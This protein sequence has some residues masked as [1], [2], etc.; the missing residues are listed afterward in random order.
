M[1]IAIPNFHANNN[2]VVKAWDGI[3]YE[4]PQGEGTQEEPYLINSAEELFWV[5]VQTEMGTL[6]GSEHFLLTSDIIIGDNWEPIGSNINNA[7]SGNFD[8]NNYT[9]KSL[10]YNDSQTINS[11]LGLFGVIN[12]A[13][14]S[15]L[16][17]SNVSY[18]LDLQNY[19]N[20]LFAGA[21]AGSIINSTISNV[22]TKGNITINNATENIYL[23]GLAGNVEDSNIETIENNASITVNNSVEVYV[24]GLTG[25]SNNV[26]IQTSYNKANLTVNN[27]SNTY[28]GGLVASAEFTS[29][30]KVFNDGDIN[31]T[32]NSFLVG[33]I[34]GYIVNTIQQGVPV[35]LVYN[36]GNITVAGL[37]E[38]TQETYVGGLFGNVGENINIDHAY[39]NNIDLIEEQANQ[40]NIIYAGAL[41]GKLNINSQIS[42]SYYNNS[43][44]EL[45][46][47][48][49]G[50]NEGT[51]NDVT[52]L[53]T[54]SMKQKSS[55]NG[56]EWTFDTLGSNWAISNSL[57]SSYPILRYVGNFAIRT[58]VSG[59]G[60]VSN[61]G[62]KFYELGTNPVYT[63]VADPGFQIEYIQIDNDISYE[64]R[65]KTFY[66]YNSI[67]TNNAPESVINLGVQFEPLFFYKT[68]LFY[69]LIGVG[70]I[71]LIMII[72]TVIINYRYETKMDRIMSDKKKSLKLD[73]DKINKKKS[74]SKKTNS[75]KKN[76]TN[77]TNKIS[78]SNKTSKPNKAKVKTDNTDNK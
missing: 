3:T 30:L 43:L 71:V 25:T 59:H 40:A 62:I 15:N 75:P 12:N 10:I 51:I 8:G 9:I 45:G 65:G 33:G 52:Y 67:K 13:T 46:N 36:V 16:R 44:D 66:T 69:W 34:A 19:N 17:I 41:I 64:Q 28:L 38:L 1:V 29:F 35:S 63:I 7:F 73:D 76:K 5:S 48:G 58:Q 32:S 61:S 42:F 18:N 72:G 78:K 21:L 37:D 24:G 56:S 55:Y 53:Q 14:I 31:A 22:I 68:Q 47:N 77:K 6:L 20:Q 2:L 57:N 11:Y 60:E 23:G 27:S 54:I 49:V 26:G 39:T 70:T 74:K 4:T 50:I